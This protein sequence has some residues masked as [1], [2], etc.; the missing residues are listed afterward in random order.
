M[1][2]YLLFSGMLLPAFVQYDS[3]R[4]CAIAVKLFLHA[5]S[6]HIVGDQ[7]ICVRIQQAKLGQQNPHH[8]IT[9]GVYCDFSANTYLPI[10]KSRLEVTYT[11]T[12]F[13]QFPSYSLNG[14]FNL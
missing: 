2:L 3:K 13:C 4:S 5:L 14:R 9:L 6:V 10:T 12:R 7:Y 8:T 11:T 1:I